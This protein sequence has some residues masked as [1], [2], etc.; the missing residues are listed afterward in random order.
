MKKFLRK[1]IRKIE[2]IHEEIEDR[3]AI[4]IF[5]IKK[6]KGRPFEEVMKDI[7]IEKPD[8]KIT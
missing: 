3:I 5:T 6:D 7:G 4:F 8:G 2:L 1:L